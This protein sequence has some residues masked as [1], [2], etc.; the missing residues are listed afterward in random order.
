MAKPQKDMHAQNIFR[1]EIQK[2]LRV[3]PGTETTEVWGEIEVTSP[4][5]VNAADLRLKSIQNLILT[6]DTSDAMAGSTGHDIFASKT[7]YN[8]GRKGNQAS[9]YLWDNDSDAQSSGSHYVN[10]LAM[11]E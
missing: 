8:K 9:I 11:G 1:L 4:A 5:R 2:E 10:F 7:I 6:V 3:D